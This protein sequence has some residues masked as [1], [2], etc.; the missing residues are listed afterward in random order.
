[1]ADEGEIEAEWDL[2][3]ARSRGGRWLTYSAAHELAHQVN[4]SGTQLVFLDPSLLP[5]LDAARPLLTRAFPHSRVV[6]LCTK[7]NKPFPTPYK[8]VEELFGTV[9]KPARFDGATE[10]RS[11]AWLCYSSGT[12]GLPKGVMTSHWNLTSQLQAVN[13]AYEPLEYGRDVVLGILPFSHIYG[14]TVVL[15]QPITVGV[16]VITLP[17]FEEIPVLRA[18][19]RVSRDNCLSL[20]SSSRSR[21][22]SSSLPSLSCSST[23]QMLQST[24]SARSVP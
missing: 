10:A 23:R 22:A 16:P 1:V 6:L 19:E 2:E 13:V 20:T 21:T 9:G 17:K 7:E 24:T 4:N 11:T 15:L 5:T 3:H 8:C 18:I 12:T 14:L